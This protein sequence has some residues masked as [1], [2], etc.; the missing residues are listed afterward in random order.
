MALD[1][2][3]QPR[4][5]HVACKIARGNTPVPEAGDQH[6]CGDGEDLWIMMTYEKRGVS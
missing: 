4:V 2:L 1:Q 5:V 3:S 6:K